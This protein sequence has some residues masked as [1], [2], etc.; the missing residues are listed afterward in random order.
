MR[1]TRIGNSLVQLSVFS[2]LFVAV[3]AALAHG[4]VTNPPS[5]I[6]RCYQEGPETPDSAA[7][8]AAIALDGTQPYYDWMGVRQGSANGNHQDVV[9]DGTLCSGGNSGGLD[10]ARN[11]WVA[12]DIKSGPF[13]FTWTNTAPHATAYYRYY[14]TKNDYDLTQPLRWND[15][16]LI[17]DTGPE[18]P[19]SSAN[20]ACNLPA[21]E[22]KHVI[23]SVWQRSDSPEAFY[24]CADVN[25]G[26]GEPNPPSGENPCT[27]LPKWNKKSI[28][29]AGQQVRRKGGV[30]KANFRNKHRNPGR[31]SGPGKEWTR[32]GRCKIGGTGIAPVANANG[33]YA[34]VV[35]ENIQFTS[36]G[37]SD[38]D[39]TIKKYIWRFGDGSVS[40]GVSNPTHRYLSTGTYTVRLKVIDNQGIST[41]DSAVVE[42]ID[43]TVN[44]SPSA[45]ANGP[46]NGTPGS[47]ISF[48]ST[49]SDD[50]DGSIVSYEWEFGDGDSS[51]ETTPRHFYSEPGRYSITLR[52]TDNEGATA[53]SST[54][55]T[56]SAIMAG[57]KKVVGYFA[58]WGVYARNYHV[59]NIVT[60]GSADKLTHLVYA[61]G[62][63]TDGRCVIGDSY[64]D[65]DRF[66]DV[67]ESV[68]G[69]AD[70][71]DSGVL[72]GSFNQ[73]RKLK[74]MYPQIKILWSFGGWTWSGG[75]TQAAANPA[76]FAESCYDLIHDS[77]WEGLF[78]GI[79]ID[80]EYPNECGLICDTSGF[81]AYGNLMAALRARFGSELVTAAI[82]AGEAKLN[83]ANYGSAVQYVDFYM[84]MTYDFFGAWAAQGPTAPHSPLYNFDG[85]PVKG[86]FADNAVQVLKAKGVP[87]DKILLGVGFYGRG[88]SGVGQVSAA[89]SSAVGAASGT[90]ESGIED[91]KILKNT[92]P[93]TGIIAGTAY[94]N[95]GDQYW[96][97]DTPGTLN[98]KMD[99]LKNQGLGGV[100]FWELSGD[101]A[102]GELINAISNG[103]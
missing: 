64:A 96:S 52:V 10:L 101:T 1:N 73:L 98:G 70:T 5:R 31:H 72:R 17:C 24:A 18:G 7:C 38:P 57:E 48:T 81:D 9:P 76:A 59:K 23:Y 33:P 40:R 51:I 2:L 41:T 3:E 103:L 44:Q 88:W 47:E 4:T 30:Y 69:K 28:Y 97:Y 82:G 55:A 39:G 83:A 95:C 35:G 16:T 80:W 86:L 46:Y 27:N 90:Y 26:G 60:S 32:I 78:D 67:A 92:C 66:Y 87:A 77:R 34:G 21:R 20:H 85:I 61:F 63:V 74:Q 37:T 43:S 50:P 13:T 22:G 49:G 25:F 62:N 94:A 53:K 84:L 65:Y 58:Q 42:I 91:Y 29:V 6:Y 14:I 99:Y 79:D 54:T 71:W 36:D 93:A 12:G 19:N 56:I 75:F 68:D 15:L 89:G 100:F 102:E 11:D 8:Q 45:K